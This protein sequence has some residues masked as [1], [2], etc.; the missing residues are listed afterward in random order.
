MSEVSAPG[1][2]ANG[3]NVIGAGE[4]RGRPSQLFL[5]WFAAN[6]SVLGLSYGAW[7]LSFG[8]SAAQALAV[9]VVGIVGSFLLVGFT[10]LAGQRG[11]APTMVLSRAAF[12]VRGNALPTAVGYLVL[13]GWE[14]ILVA[15]AVLMSRTVAAR[16]GWGSGEAAPIFTFVLVV[17]LIM[18]AGIRGFDIVMRAQRLITWATA[19]LTIGYLVLVADRIRPEALSQMPAGPLSGVAGA[20]VFFLTG[21]GL[22]WVNSAADYSRYL[23]REASAVGVVGWTTLGASLPLIIL[24][25]AGVLLAA[26]D[27]TLAEGIGSDPIGALTTALPTWYV[28]PFALVALLGLLGGA[29]LDIYSSGLTLLTLGL[30]VPR[31]QA[32]ALDGVLMVLGTIYVVW[33]AADFLGPFQGFLIT[34]GV[35]LAAWVGIF[36]GDLALRRRGYD[37]TALYDARGPYGSVNG[38]AIALFG[39]GSVLGWGLVTNHVMS[40]Q[41]YLLGPFGGRDSAAGAAGLGVFVAIV[42]GF[43]GTLAWSRSRVRAQEARWAAAATGSPASADARK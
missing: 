37:E 20:F 31:W 7:V 32:V 38:G 8:I 16:L 26:S 41:G 42:V 18:A 36:L 2:E 6:V 29:I 11:S 33:I 12:G 40:W 28:L 35:P 14:V 24:I 43:V 15:L 21:L 3:I 19:I 9:A 13:V 23:P 22:S 10:S 25:G 27:P 39:V 1:I 34:L 30:P 4:R 17:A 5:P